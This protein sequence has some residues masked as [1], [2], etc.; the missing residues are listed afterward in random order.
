MH[1]SLDIVKEVYDKQHY[2]LENIHNRME[3]G[4]Y[5]VF[6]TAGNGRQKLA[7]I[8][9]NQYLTWCYEH[10]STIEG[11]LITFG[12]NFGKY[13]EHIISAINTAA[14]RTKPG[15]LSIYIGAYTEEDAEHI[16]KIQGKFLCK[17]VHIFDAKTVDVW[18]SE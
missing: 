9:H 1:K 15:L 6:V 16:K 3:A 17:K 5:P 2:I 4:D 14:T 7:H 12:F 18:G 11:S 8:M 13:D 10:L